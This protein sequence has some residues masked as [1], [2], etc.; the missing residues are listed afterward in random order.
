MLFPA[1][2]N[3]N[4][5]YMTTSMLFKIAVILCFFSNQF[6]MYGQ[7][8]ERIIYYSEFGAVGDGITDDFDA[9]IK[10]HDAAN[11][12][13]LKVRADAGASYYIG[14]ADKAALILTD[15]DWVDAKFIIDDR[16]V[17]NRNRYVFNVSSKLTPIRITTVKTLV[18]NQKKLDLL[19]PYNSFIVV[20]DNTTMRYI[21][22]GLNQ[23]NGSA[24]TDVFVVDKTGNVDMKAPIIWDYNNITT[25][26]AYPIDPETLTISGGNFTT[27][28]NQAESQYTYYSRSIGITRSNVV[29]DGIYHT[30]TGELDQGAPYN[31][32]IYISR[33]TEVTVQNCKLSGHKTYVTIGAADAPVSMGSYDARVNSSTNVIFRNCRQINDIHNTKL[34]GI[35][36]SDYS[37]NILFDSVEFSRFDAHMGV[38]N[39]TIK[40]SVLGHQGINIIG[41]GIFLIENTKVY[42]TNLINLRSDYGSTWEGEIIIRNCE[43]TPRNSAVSDA[44][45]I[46]GS[47]SGQ[48]DF[49]YKCYMPEKILINGLVINDSNPVNDYRGPKIFAPFN[50]KYTSEEYKEKYPYEITKEI[51]I[52]N[53]TIK[54][55]KKYLVSNNQ[56]MF[57]NVR[58]TE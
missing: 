11:E 45:L 3:Y 52:K 21:R 32:F 2:L 8:S 17:E 24:Q 26:T 4:Y 22:E 25:M 1:L 54:S 14:G 37:K 44:V 58:I 46:N 29:V 56:F 28:A 50:N 10:A 18:K 12:A 15:T 47:Y 57:R 35:F 7:V 23:N 38:A 31:G 5:R 6:G 27:I 41:T 42:G 43:Y 49:G 40:N 53:L 36:A 20:T 55:G 16:N 39:A 30:I 19:L 34:W 9:I 33:C 51:D 13:G 48:H